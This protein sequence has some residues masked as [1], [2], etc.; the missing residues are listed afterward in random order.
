MNILDAV[1]QR[2]KGER[3]EEYHVT[4]CSI[5]DSAYP[6]V[7]KLRASKITPHVEEDNTVLEYGVG[8]GWNLALL[9][10]ERRLGFDLSEFLE[11]ILRR[12]GIE[13]VEDPAT[14][15]V[16][17]IDVVVCHHMLEH[18]INPPEVLKEIGRVL[19][20]KGK[21]LLFVPYEKEK[22][23]YRY[24]AEEPNHHLYSW[25][26]QTLSNLVEDTGFKVVEGKLGRFGY[27]RFAAT[28]ATRFRLGEFGFRFL[29]RA[30]HL[31]KPGFEV[32]IVAERK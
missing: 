16:A 31:V 20:S 3:G 4:T 27:D 6:W 26:V 32:Q 25:N 28:W 14:I 2:Y 7:A 21:L 13:S 10:C 24:D 23:Y 11:P 18:T 5:P 1:E 17:S 22:R 19:R 12:H 9:K 30:I 29:R 8:F 15:P